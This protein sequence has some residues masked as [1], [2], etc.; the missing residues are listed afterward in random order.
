MEF[1]RPLSQDFEQMVVLQ[2]KNLDT[3]LPQQQL[4][5]GFLSTA[6]TVEQFKMMDHQLC[7]IVCI[8]AGSV[9][10]Y[11]CASTIELNQSFPLQ[12]VMLDYCSQCTYNKIPLMS[13]RSF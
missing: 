9:C 7:V 4:A 5:D 2:N 1:R 13:Y 12:A 8:D 11:L 6:F 3:T 10:G